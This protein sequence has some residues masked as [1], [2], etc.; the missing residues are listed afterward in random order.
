LVS[1]RTSIP[2]GVGVGEGEGEVTGK[3]KA[4]EKAE[5]RKQEAGEL[6]GSGGRVQEVP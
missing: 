1:E 5:S 3:V 2:G 6:Q 4:S